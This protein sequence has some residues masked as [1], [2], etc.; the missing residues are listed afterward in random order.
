MECVAI[1]HAT[2]LK[3][4]FIT[5]NSGIHSFHYYHGKENQELHGE[6]ARLER[7]RLITIS[8]ISREFLERVKFLPASL[9]FSIFNVSFCL[10]M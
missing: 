5:N 3:G 7:S 4:L 2:S 6:F 1:S 10:I 9:F 8:D